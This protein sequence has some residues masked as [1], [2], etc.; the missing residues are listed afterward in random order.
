M[1]LS[2]A[3]RKVALPFAEN[4]EKNTIPEDSSPSPGFASMNDGFPPLTRQP[5]GSGGIPPQGLDMNGILYYLSSLNKWQSAGGSFVYDSTFATDSDV[6][7]YPKGAVLLRSGGDGF[8]LNLADN[9][10]NNPDTGGANWQPINNVGITSKTLTGSDV[11]LTNSEAA[12][13][14]IV[15]SGTLTANV[16]LIVPVFVKQWI[17]ANNTTGAFTVTVKTASGTGGLVTQST[18]RVFYGDGTN[19]YGVNPLIASQAQ[20]N[21]GTDNSTFLTPKTFKDSQ[22]LADKAD[23]N[24]NT[25]NRFKIAAA[26]DSDES[27]R[28]DQLP[29]AATQAQVN[30]GTDTLTFLTPKTFKDSQLLADKA[31]KNGNTSN[32]FKIAAAVD[33][34]EAARK[35]QLPVAAT[36]L[37]TGLVRKATQAEM[38]AGTA[39]A[40]PSAAE[41]FNGFAS[42]GTTNGYIKLPT[43]LSGL[44]L[45]WGFNNSNT[46]P[47]TISFPI[48]FT[49]ACYG[50]FAQSDNDLSPTEVEYTGVSDITTTTFVW[51]GIRAGVTAFTHGWW[52]A[53]GK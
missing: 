40:F 11:T 22:L 37:L 35:D 23:K 4:G 10:V 18:N 17:V 46:N 21:T 2:N 13:D 52:F 25:S 51:N 39:D 31:D 42:S 29:L 5:V 41:I 24:G 28:K 14:I 19:I 48:A 47:L 3:P 33:N 1:L 34:D 6:G 45:Q 12:K 27:V 50:V 36:T 20:V 7:G 8:W 26:V 53:I 38:N 9:N 43:Y 30:T 49:T 44:I 32:R 16:N 15:L